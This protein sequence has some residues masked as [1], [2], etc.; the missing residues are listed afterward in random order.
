MELRALRDENRALMAVLAYAVE[1]VGGTLVVPD[2]I[3]VDE[4]LILVREEV[5]RPEGTVLHSRPRPSA[6]LT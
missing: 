6:H 4:P 3:I 2:N 5:V 1:Q